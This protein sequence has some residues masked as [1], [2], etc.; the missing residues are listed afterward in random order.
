MAFNGVNT[1]SFFLLRSQ[2]NACATKERNTEL[3]DAVKSFILTSLK[4]KVAPYP[5]IVSLDTLRLKYF[6]SISVFLGVK[7]Q[8]LNNH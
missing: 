3:W 7:R 2:Q 8:Y 1:V 5:I 6:W 4:I